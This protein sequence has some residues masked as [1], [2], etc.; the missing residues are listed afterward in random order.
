MDPSNRRARYSSAEAIRSDDAQRLA[1]LLIGEDALWFQNNYHWLTIQAIG[2]DAVHCTKVLIDHGIDFHGVDFKGIN[3]MHA[4]MTTSPFS[5]VHLLYQKWPDVNKLLPPTR[6]P[7]ILHAVERRIRE[8]HR[9]GEADAA[10]AFVERL[11]R[12]GARWDLWPEDYPSAA[13][14]AVWIGD[15][16]LLSLVLRNGAPSHNRDQQGNTPLLLALCRSDEQA[17][18]LLLE[19]GAAEA[20]PPE[21]RDRLL[22]VAQE[23]AQAAVLAEL[24]QRWH[25]PDGDGR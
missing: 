7:L 23:T 24:R 17:V 16:S 13:S 21:D 11:I 19:H 3:L 8:Y 1:K 22:A 5:V 2:Y 25:Q 6:M 4:A 20:A 12:D 9:Q 14:M 18:R 15:L 10:L